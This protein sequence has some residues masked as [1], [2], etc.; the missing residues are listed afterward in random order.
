VKRRPRKQRVAL[1]ARRREV[2]AG[3]LR[4][5]LTRTG[6]LLVAGIV[7]FAFAKY[8]DVLAVSFLHDYTPDLKIQTPSS[9]QGLSI[10]EL[11]PHSR[12]SLWYPWTGYGLA[13]RVR[14]KHSAVRDV[15]LH[16]D[17]TARSVEV[18]LI[19]RAPIVQ[20]NHQ[21]VDAEGVIFAMSP[22]VAEKLPKATLLSAAS[23]PALGRW[24]ARA[25]AVT[26]FW[27][28]VKEVKGDARGQLAVLTESGTW[29]TWGRPDVEGVREKAVT[30]VRVLEDA[31][32]HLGGAATA[33]L[34]FFDEGRI[35]VKPKTAAGLRN[36]EPN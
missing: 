21:G 5:V 1:R 12:F 19:P 27:R 16:R 10:A 6:Y 22:E 3:Q 17:F 26:E 23:V 25:S 11:L 36:A 8:G 30:L 15:E 13:R 24:L 4:T 33:D 20:W 28:R 34:R 14:A 31:H 18:R 32:A 9:L 29:V 35:I 7:F 2:L